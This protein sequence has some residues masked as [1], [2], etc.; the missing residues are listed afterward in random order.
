MS[1]WP[2]I[3]EFAVRPASMGIAL[4]AQAYLL[5]KSADGFL[6]F[7]GI[8]ATQN[9]LGH[10]FYPG[11]SIS[12]FRAANG[13]SKIQRRLFNLASAV[14]LALSFVVLPFWS[15]A[16]IAL[17]GTV[18]TAVNTIMAQ[19]YLGKARP[20]ISSALTQILPWST[21]IVL[22]AVLSDLTLLKVMP[23]MMVLPSS[24]IAF[25]ALLRLDPRQLDGSLQLN[26]KLGI[27]AFI[28]SFK[29]HGIS[30][31]ASPFQG[32]EVAGALF[33]VKLLSAAQNIVAYA[34][35]R[36]VKHFSVILRKSGKQAKSTALR[37]AEREGGILGVALNLGVLAFYLQP[38]LTGLAVQDA[39]NQYIIAILLLLALF[40]PFFLTSYIAVN[41]LEDGRLFLI[42][43]ASV[44]IFLVSYVC[45]LILLSPSA[46]ILVCYAASALFFM[47]ALTYELRKCVK[48]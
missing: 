30:L 43:I 21:L 15:A 38:F 46:T 11:I 25:R 20:I 22:L 36:R 2:R 9:L 29:A 47:A 16:A 19:Y 14:L 26:W 40:S 41:I 1:V 39:L 35:A 6:V 18:L 5:Q 28:Q 4:V 32:V 44:L 48:C 24:V 7:N 23:L 42:N 37:S 12:A 17:V 45:G 34:G 13:F 33:V 31:L 8:Y 10:L 3:A 27:F